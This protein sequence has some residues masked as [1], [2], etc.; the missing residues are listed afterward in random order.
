MSDEIITARPPWGAITFAAMNTNTSIVLSSSA[1]PALFGMPPAR[2]TDTDGVPMQDPGVPSVN[3]D[4]ETS[5]P[6]AANSK[7][8]KGLPRGRKAFDWVAI[9][10]TFAAV[11]GI[12]VMLEQ[13]RVNDTK[14]RAQEDR[15][16][17]EKQLADQR[18]SSATV[19]AALTARHDAEIKSLQDQNQKESASLK[20]SKEDALTALRRDNGRNMELLEKDHKAALV[21][22]RRTADENLSKLIAG[23]NELQLWKSNVDFL[24]TSLERLEAIF[25]DRVDARKKG[26]AEQEEIN[27]DAQSNLSEILRTERDIDGAARLVQA[28][29]EYSKAGAALED[30]YK[31]WHR[32]YGQ[33]IEDLLKRAN[34]DSSLKGRQLQLRVQEAIRLMDKTDAALAMKMDPRTESQNVPIIAKADADLKQIAAEIQALDVQI[35][36][37]A[38][39][40]PVPADCTQPNGI[41]AHTSAEMKG[42]GD[43]E[44]KKSAP[45]EH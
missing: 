25:G 45:G 34:S 14:E 21:E 18:E 16:T 44:I 35:A 32:R 15:V 8:T 19:V 17:L 3:T 6:A 30:T 43:T 4:T 27:R 2:T 5:N 28:F 39:K 9:I 31:G 29:D 13:D 26:I 24:R 11:L 38:A 40:P 20:D 41:W 42:L 33:C 10:G 7:T 12:V 22:L 37:A 23:L 1:R 36:A